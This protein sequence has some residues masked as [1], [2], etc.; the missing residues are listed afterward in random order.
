MLSPLDPELSNSSPTFVL[1][2][3]ALQLTYD[4]LS[5]CPSEKWALNLKTFYYAS[6][7][8]P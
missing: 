1:C 5:Y 7:F 3:D 4:A 6:H 2:S 8:L